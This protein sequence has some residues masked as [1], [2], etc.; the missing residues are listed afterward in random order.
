MVAASYENMPRLGDSGLTA[1]DQVSA[2]EADHP[3]MCQGWLKM[4]RE[5]ERT[6]T[7][8]EHMGGAIK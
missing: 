7:L 6:I 3:P 1:S 2:L 8:P 5:K 4:C